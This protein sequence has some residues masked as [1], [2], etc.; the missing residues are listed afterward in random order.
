[1]AGPLNRLRDRSW[2][3]FLQAHDGALVD[4]L[5][6]PALG[7]AVRYDRCCAYFSS[8]VLAV[9]ARGFG[10]LVQHYLEAPPAC[11]P[12]PV[13]L[14]VN[15]EMSRDDVRAL[16]E[17][18]DVAVLEHLLL[19][20]LRTPQEAIERDR[21]G[22]LG[23]LVKRGWIEVR[24]GVLRTGNGILHSKF[25]VVRDAAGDA[26]MFRGSA[27]ESASG[28]QHNVEHVEVTTSWEDAAGYE[29]FTGLFEK[30]W[31]NQHPAIETFALPDAVALKLISFA[32]D[33]LPEGGSYDDEKDKVA[34]P[35]PPQAVQRAVDPIARRKTAMLWRYLVESPYLPNGHTVCD[36]TALVDMWPHQRR[37]VEETSSAWP[38]G[39][40]LCDEVGMGK[41][42]EAI[43]VLRRLLA[44]R[45][46]RR[47]LILLP[48]G[49][50]RQWQSELREKGGLIVPRLQGTSSLFWPDGREVAV[51]G[52]AAAVRQPLLIVSREM[53][54]MESNL[55]ILLA[56][57]PWDLV[58]LDESHAARRKEAK[59]SAFNQAN[60]LLDLLRQL[61]LRQRA[62]SI[63]LLSATPMQTQAW[64]P[65][66]L[67]GVLGE[68]G[69]WIAEFKAVQHY[70]AAIAS[71]ETG[72][73]E[74]EIALAAADVLLADGRVKVLPN[75][76]AL[77]RDRQ[78]L[79]TKLQFAPKSERPALVAWLRKASP[80]AR[81]IHR[82]TRDTLREYHRIGILDKAPAYRRVEDLTYEYCTP[83]ERE[84]YKELKNYIERRFQELE[85]ERPGK[86]FVMTIY[87]R[88]MAS[89]PYAI[90]QSLTRRLEGLER[91]MKRFAIDSRSAEDLPE[92]VTGDDVGDADDMG[93]ISAAFPTDPEQA[94][95]E[96]ADVQKLL[97]ALTGLHGQ[98]TKRDRFFSVLQSVMQDGRAVLVFTEYSD[99]MKYLR[100]FLV[101]RY[102]ATLGTYSGE[103][104]R[105][106]EDGRWINVTKDV[107][108]KRLRD[109]KLRVLLCTDAASEGLNLQAAGAVINYDLPWNPS[110]VEQRIGRVD[111]IGQALTEIRVINFFLEDSVDQRVYE[112]LRTRCKMFEGFIGRMQPVLAK[113]QKML[114]G[115][116]PADTRILEELAQNQDADI[117]ARETFAQDAEMPPETLSPLATRDSV[118]CALYRLAEGTHAT[119]SA[120]SNRV[121]VSGLG[122]AFSVGLTQEALEGDSDALPPT[123]TH[124]RFRQIA[125]LLERSDECLPLVVEAAASGA[126]RVAKATWLDGADGRIEV[127]SFDHLESLVAAWNGQLADE[128]A[129][130]L[131]VEHL[132]KTS[133]AE[134]R[135]HEAEANVKRRALVSA[136]MASAR[137]RL[138]LELGRYLGCLDE[139]VGDL[140]GVFYRQMTRD[141]VSQ[142]RLG[143]C[144]QLLGRAY[145]EWPED[146]VWDVENTVEALPA[147]R[148]QARL[149]GNELE[150]ALSDP[151]WMLAAAIAV[152]GLPDEAEL[153][154]YRPEVRKLFLNAIELVTRLKKEGWKQQDFA[155]ALIQLL[156]D[157]TEEGK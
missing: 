131:A 5:Y 65:W 132:R 34:E 155:K 29:H 35:A 22:L 53:A 88:R 89:A 58:L 24:V 106:F 139:G 128:G 12:P 9:A 96:H 25:G 124:P 39:R 101:D 21:L 154:S 95:R 31:D 11:P 49:L 140:N 62:R 136:Q 112:V 125:E 100:D 63:M 8:S 3:R 2:R 123:V 122:D 144:F 19:T 57:E 126:F 15:E 114:R 113:A 133:A 50:L 14:L 74:P 43:L 119:V 61:Q 108:T 111:R 93:E 102:Q 129:W 26:L 64:E 83:G 20:R 1:M 69:P 152:D 143:R 27:N 30:M 48:A 37:V 142:K 41:T 91:V 46:V 4:E 121:G 97:K 138:L 52:L 146:I 40:L 115:Q 120:D 45:G 157:G 147:N 47:V 148:Q 44:G 76:Q 42:I 117:L 135:N 150:A 116:E 77:P 145:P 60:L 13:R 32:P 127:A 38:D 149:I 103:G 141:I 10:A 17:A 7:V 78:A 99:T 153:A 98:D 105:L 137:R 82:N 36:A 68:G 86:G 80:I 56:A 73:W 71:L 66:D 23:Y 72:K 54:R 110:K 134:A 33:E 67:L 104:G 109:R 92:G 70:Y 90:T 55:G 84:I 18:R 81:R 59:E 130:K 79:A 156:Q 87:Q 151:R 118:R 107:I 75:G 94:A 28:L 6:N 85:G 51:D 16:T